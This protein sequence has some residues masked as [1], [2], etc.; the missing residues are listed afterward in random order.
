MD[1]LLKHIPHKQRIHLLFGPQ[2]LRFPAWT[3]L[4]NTQETVSEKIGCNEYQINQQTTKKKNSTNSMICIAP[5]SILIYF[6]FFP[7]RKLTIIPAA[8]TGMAFI[9]LLNLSSTR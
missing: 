3:E 7:K 4:G 9:A 6:F 8:M 1:L 2:R 5:D